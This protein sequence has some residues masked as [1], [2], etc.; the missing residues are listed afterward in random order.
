MGIHNVKS[1]ENTILRIINGF[2]VIDYP[3]NGNERKNLYVLSTGAGLGMAACDL[4]IQKYLTKYNIKFKDLG[5][6]DDLQKAA[7]IDYC[8]TYFNTVLLLWLSVT[9]ISP[10]TQNLKERNHLAFSGFVY[11]KGLNS[12]K[13]SNFMDMGYL[14]LNELSDLKEV[15]FK[16]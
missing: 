12:E 13:V 2:D 9:D 16:T 1:S 4:I 14:Q 7:L 15:E 5:E 8:G 3:S 11:M 10:I 6:L